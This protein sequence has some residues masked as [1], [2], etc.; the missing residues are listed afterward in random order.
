MGKR[1][2]HDV[3]AK[4]HES[5]FPIIIMSEHLYYFSII[6]SLGTISYTKVYIKVLTI[7]SVEI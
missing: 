2:L 6:Y 1:D 7:G 3:C 4:M 5:V